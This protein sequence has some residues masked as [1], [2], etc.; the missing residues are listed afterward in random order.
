M[1]LG[2]YAKQINGL[3]RENPETKEMQVFYSVDDEGN[4]YDSVKFGPAV[5]ESK[6]YIDFKERES[7]KISHFVC[8]N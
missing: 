7:E 3:L 5:Y 6:G 4:S 8:I 1:T 2:E